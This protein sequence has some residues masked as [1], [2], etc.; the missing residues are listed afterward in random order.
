MTVQEAYIMIVGTLPAIRPMIS[1]PMSNETTSNVLV[2]MRCFTAN[3]RCSLVIRSILL[4]RLARTLS[5]LVG[6]SWPRW[7]A[8]QPVQS[9]GTC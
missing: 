4:I 8:T 5:S 9:F 6:T 3:L 1:V 2:I 7:L